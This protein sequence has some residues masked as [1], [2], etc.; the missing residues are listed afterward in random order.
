VLAISDVDN[1]ARGSSEADAA[2]GSMLGVRSVIT[3]PAG[4]EGALRA[5]LYVH[6]T[7]VREWRRSDAA[8]ARD[9]AERSWAAVERAESEQ[10][11]RESE[12]HYRH[13]VELNPQ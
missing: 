6:E 8:M 5:L 12:D 9:V 11:L 10:R 1:L 7:E 13:A 2:L 4:R 3:G